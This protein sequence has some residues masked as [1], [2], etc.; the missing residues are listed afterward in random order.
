MQWPKTTLLHTY[1]AHFLSP[2]EF[3]V[4]TCFCDDGESPG[5]LYEPLPSEGTLFRLDVEPRRPDINR[6]C[7]SSAESA[8][9]LVPL[10][11]AEP[12]GE[13]P[14]P[15]FS[16]F[17]FSN[18]SISFRRSF[19]TMS[20]LHTSFPLTVAIPILSCD[21]PV[22]FNDARRPAPDGSP[23]SSMVIFIFDGDLEYS[24]KFHRKKGW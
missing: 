3:D 7:S 5:L 6:V 16:V 13:S 10:R 24:W 18:P 2:A 14:R 20:T 17:I 21:D 11:T 9:P 4:A 1:L 22:L 12:V 23:P 8:S 15:F 19:L